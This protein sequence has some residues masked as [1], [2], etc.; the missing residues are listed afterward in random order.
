MGLIRE[1]GDPFSALHYS[2]LVDADVIVFDLGAQFVAFI[3]FEVC[4][5]TRLWCF[6]DIAGVEFMLL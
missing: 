1:L 6:K 5:N 4:A 2:F 3:N